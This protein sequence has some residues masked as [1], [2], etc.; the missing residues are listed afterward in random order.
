[1]I[2]NMIYIANIFLIKG[3]NCG[4]IQPLQNGVVVGNGTLYD[5]SIQFVCDT[6]YAL[7]GD[8]TAKCLDTGNWSVEVPQCIRKYNRNLLIYFLI[9][10]I[11]I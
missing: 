1:M 7:V 4:E 8:D 10:H 2:F 9:F 11:I 5:D 3:K 6:G